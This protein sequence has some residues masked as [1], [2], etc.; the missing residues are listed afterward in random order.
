MADAKHKPSGKKFDRTRK[1]FAKRLNFKRW[2]SWNEIKGSS[3]NL[4]NMV[5]SVLAI[6]E[7]EHI[8][9]FCEAKARLGLS[10]ADIQYQYQRIWWRAKVM[11]A[12]GVLVL[13]YACYLVVYANVVAGGIV[14]CLAA[15]PSFALSFRDSF[16]AYQI[17]RQRL[18]CTV[19]EWVRDNFWVA[20][21][22]FRD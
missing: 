5:K 20:K 19:E 11:F 17:R 9:T 21:L 14:T 22:W 18:G 12:V 6:K 3:L 7:P 13:I 16:W 15:G 4:V 2:M 10:D 8:E 1:F